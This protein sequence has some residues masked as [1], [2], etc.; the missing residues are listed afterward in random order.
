MKHKHDKK[1]LDPT[2]ILM[3]M[4]YLL[5]SIP[6]IQDLILTLCNNSFCEGK[7]SSELKLTRIIPLPKVSN[8]INLDQFR[9]I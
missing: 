3:N 8:P 6:A 7:V 4:V 1:T 2:N 5:I 9:P